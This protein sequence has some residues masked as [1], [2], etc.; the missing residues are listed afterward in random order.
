[1]ALMAVLVLRGESAP[2]MY[3]R[4][5]GAATVAEASAMARHTPRAVGPF[6]AA[7]CALA[8]CGVL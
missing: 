7:A 8:A 1:M 2:S 3:G 4:R 6:A 5:A